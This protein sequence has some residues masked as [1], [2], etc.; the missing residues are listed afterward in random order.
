M[1]DLSN[2]QDTAAGR[3]PSSGPSEVGVERHLHRDKTKWSDR[4]YPFQPAGQFQT[5]AATRQAMTKRIDALAKRFQTGQKVRQRDVEAF[6]KL[7][8]RLGLRERNLSTIHEALQ[9]AARG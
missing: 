8:K 1:S 7:E 5:V 4:R 9:G 6:R 3:T 2:V